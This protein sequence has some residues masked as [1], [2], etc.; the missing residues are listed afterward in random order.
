[1][2]KEAKLIMNDKTINLTNFENFMY[3]DY[4]ENDVQINTNSTEVNGVDGVLAG[5]STFAPF[6]LELRFI[7]SGVD[8][9]GTLICLVRNTQYY[10]ALLK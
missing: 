5:A 6:E 7:F 3:L 4:I 9:H 8:I 1:M 10:Q 2:K